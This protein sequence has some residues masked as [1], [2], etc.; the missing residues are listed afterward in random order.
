MLA[1][2]T[3]FVVEFTTI[4]ENPL[5]LVAL[6]AW[7]IT[8]AVMIWQ[9]NKLKMELKALIK[10]PRE[11]LKTNFEEPWSS[12]TTA[13]RNS[14]GISPPP[15]YTTMKCLPSESETIVKWAEY[16]VERVLARMKEGIAK[17]VVSEDKIEA[18]KAIPEAGGGD[19]SQGQA[20]DAAELG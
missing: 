10:G 16:I 6:A 12:L 14:Q 7:G 1:N 17:G 18:V 8:S 11:E 9:I 2:E 20:T 5:L 19:L 3:F 15:A 4:Y 13:I